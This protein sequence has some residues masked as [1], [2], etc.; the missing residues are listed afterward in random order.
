VS[1]DRAALEAV[2]RELQGP[3]YRLALRMLG[4]I[5][6]AEDATQEI[7]VVIATHLSQFRGDSKLTTWAYTIAA[8]HLFGARTSR[9]EQ[10]ALP[11]AELGALIDAGLAA[12]DDGSLAEGDVAVLAR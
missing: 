9:A 5:A 6:D 10:R 1:G 4:D 12:T 7:L 3:M 8:R 11:V 2:C